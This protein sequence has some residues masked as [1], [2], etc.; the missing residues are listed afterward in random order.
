K[1]KQHQYLKDDEALTNYLTQ[2]A[3][4][5]ASLHVNEEAPPIQGSRLEALV[6]EYRQVM[7]TIARL[8]RLYP[9]EA[10]QGLLYIEPLS[11]DDLANQPRVLTWCSALQ[12]RLEFQAV[13]SRR[14]EVL[15]IENKERHIYLPEIRVISHGV[16]V[17]YRIQRDFFESGEYRAITALGRQLNNLLEA[18]AYIKRGEKTFATRSF[19]SALEWLMAESKKGHSIQRYK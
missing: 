15:P 14:Y 16:P 4:E 19:E 18:G 2:S 8:S 1:G 11:L 7:A 3:L 10:L 5:E 6:H 13:T 9:P 12:A 17:I